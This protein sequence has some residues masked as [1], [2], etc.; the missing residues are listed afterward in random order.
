M[1]G[2]ACMI[3]MAL[4]MLIPFSRPAGSVEA[5]DKIT[6]L[7][8]AGFQTAMAQAGKVPP[9]G[10]GHGCLETRKAKLGDLVLWFQGFCRPGD[11]NQHGESHADHADAAH[12]QVQEA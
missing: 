6:Q 11:R 10:M 2:L 3:S 12:Q 1:V 4:A 8:L 9:A 5:E 7:C